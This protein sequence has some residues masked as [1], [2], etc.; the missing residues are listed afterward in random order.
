MN[1]DVAS[2]LDKLIAARRP[3]EFSGYDP[4]SGAHYRITVQNGIIHTQPFQASLSEMESN[5]PG[6]R[7]L[8]IGATR[9][10]FGSEVWPQF[11]HRDRFEGVS[12]TI[13]TPNDVTCLIGY[14]GREIVKLAA[15][16][17][18]AG[19]VPNLESLAS[20]RRDQGRKVG[21]AA[22]DRRSLANPAMIED[23]LREWEAAGESVAFEAIHKDAV[24]PSKSMIELRD[25]GV[26]PAVAALWI[27][28]RRALAV[29]PSRSASARHMFA[30]VV[31]MVFSRLQSAKNVAAALAELAALNSVS[32]R[33]PDVVGRRLANLSAA[34]KFPKAW[35]RLPRSIALLEDVESLPKAAAWRAVGEL[36]SPK[37]T[38]VAGESR[39]LPARTN[40]PLESMARIGPTLPLI[41]TE[42]LLTEYGLAGVEL[43]NSLGS[44][45][46]GRLPDLLGTALADARRVLGEWIVSLAKKGNLAVG[47][48][49][50]G[51]G[52]GLAHY[53]PDLRVINLTRKAGDGSLAHELAH[54]IDHM[55]SSIGPKGTSMFLSENVM[56][57]PVPE[58]HP[59]ASAMS[60]VMKQV[61]TNSGPRTLNGNPAATR[62]F[63]KNWVLKGWETSAGEAQGAFD[64]LADQYP[65]QFRLGRKALENAQTLADSLARWTGAPI[66]IRAPFSRDSDFL[67]QANELGDY[68][69]RPI[70]LFARCFESYVEDTL[71]AR[72]EVNEFLVAGTR[73][74]YS[75]CRGWPYPQG[76]ERACIGRALAEMVASI[77]SF[78][79]S[80]LS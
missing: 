27:L 59:V 25:G 55:L 34:A 26:P 4:G 73:E 12:I 61:R 14:P 78:P 13:Q 52:R 71:A 2:L 46:A 20:R 68:W 62:R 29:R 21:R 53:E 10:V 3:V 42:I 5:P 19:L 32:D 15:E 44:K 58:W 74:D 66:T 49:S 43:G 36:L 11:Q 7:V 45:L 77:N 8:R 37:R 70:E 33:S 51:H 17:L 38:K 65:R 22:K 64:L 35:W 39:P 47:L 79:D 31:P 48:G 56:R 54:F 76:D 72:G 24:L 18:P 69:K 1:D 40:K 57:D 63:R 30:T 80:F 75:G 67:R 41:T 6:P 50:R 16:S 9:H 28:S 23:L 60:R